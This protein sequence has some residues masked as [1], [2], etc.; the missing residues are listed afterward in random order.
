MGTQSR[1]KLVVTA[2][3]GVLPILLLA[4]GCSSTTREVPLYTQG[5]VGISLRSFAKQTSGAALKYDHPATVS[6][7]VASRIL[8]A[9]TLEEHSFLKWREQ[10]TIF[11]PE[12]VALLAPKL[13]EGLRRASPDQW[14]YFSSRNVP[15]A[16]TFG[17]IRFSD[18]IAFVKDGKL[19][20][21]FGNIAFVENV[22]TLPS[23]LDPRDIPTAADTRLAAKSVLGA[24]PPLIPGD[25]WLGHER[26]NW[27]VFDLAQVAATPP[28]PEAVATTPAAPPAAPP[29]A[30]PAVVA[31][32]PPPVVVAPAPAASAGPSSAAS[33]PPPA[34]RDAEERLRKL[35]DLR[36]KGLITPEEYEK[37]RQ[38]IL[39]GL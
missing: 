7:D 13:A 33:A 26:T 21:V 27:L 32:A 29:A 39:K 12:D 2:A 34:P 8:A 3:S 1:Q 36:D 17:S 24:A 37:K 14:V 10:G 18:G 22:D 38:E 28:P 9:V 16:L 15:R 23:K 5:P 20:L 25:R 6:N 11:A 35:K 19:N 4:V 30:A 31:P